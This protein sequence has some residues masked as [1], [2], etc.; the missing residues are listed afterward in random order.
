MMC[1]GCSCSGIHWLMKISES[2]W[3]PLGVHPLLTQPPS[4]RLRESEYLPAVWYNHL[5]Q[6][7][8]WVCDSVCVCVC[9][10]VYVSVCVFLLCVCVRALAHICLHRLGIM[11]ECFKLALETYLRT[12]CIWLFSQSRKARRR[13]GR[14]CCNKEKEKEKVCPPCPLCICLSLSVCLSASLSPLRHLFGAYSLWVSLSL[15]LSQ[16]NSCFNFI[17]L[18]YMCPLKSNCNVI[19]FLFCF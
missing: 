11:F 6:C 2:C 5:W 13:W 7:H 4:V 1:A 19:V 10:T 15:F 9:V 17:F 3:W 18:H 14:G 8:L 16:F 12:N